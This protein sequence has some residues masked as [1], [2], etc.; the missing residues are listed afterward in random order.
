LAV[1]P[2]GVPSAIGQELKAFVW[3]VLGEAAKILHG[4]LRLFENVHAG[5]GGH[6]IKHQVIVPSTG[7][8]P[9]ETILVLIW[10]I[11]R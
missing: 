9:K 7:V 11:E 10:G 5:G 2:I 8:P 4:S 1:H 3:D 6:R